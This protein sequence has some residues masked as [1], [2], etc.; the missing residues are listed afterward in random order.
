[1]VGIDK[2]KNDVNEAVGLPGTP[3]APRWACIKIQF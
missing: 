3:P 1:M 2:C